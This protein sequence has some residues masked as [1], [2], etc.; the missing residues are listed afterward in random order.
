MKTG[1]TIPVHLGDTYVIYKSESLDW[2]LKDL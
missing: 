2:L 1:I